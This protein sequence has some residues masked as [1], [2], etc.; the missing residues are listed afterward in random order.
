[1]K[2][3]GIETAVLRIPTQ[4]PVALEF[5]EHKM[6]VALV[7]TDEGLTGLGYSLAFGGGGAEAIR[8][9]LDTR[10]VPLLVGED[11]LFVERH[12]ER[13]F[14]AD[15]GIKRQGVAAYAL[16]ALDIALWDLVGQVAGLPLYKLWGAVTDRVPAYGSGGWGNYA[17][18]DVVAKAE[19]YV[20]RGCRYYKVKIHHPD[21]RV[22]RER[23]ATVRRAVGDDIGLMV[24][25]NQKLDVLGNLRQA[26][27]LE[28]LGL[29]WYEEPVLADDIAAC[30]EVARS[31]RIPV[32]TGENAY[33]RYEFRELIA[34][35]A[36]RYLMPDVCRANGYSETLR[37]ARLA[38]AH[39]VQVSPHVV[40][41]LSL[42]VVGALPNGFLVE[43]MDWAPPDLFAGLAPCEDGQF[44]IPDRAGHGVALA[45]GAIE[46][47][48]VA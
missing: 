12:W 47:Y 4:K 17:I 15:R 29:V 28:D 34:A 42:H 25:V 48:R 21:P 14:R 43:Y 1:M 31:I 32:A 10:L 46:R 22:N 13:M 39:Q 44:R 30:A 3:T 33:T 40:H 36:A 18:G 27:L 7:R 20:G 38:A 23:V 35:R 45:P 24:D 6:V 16:S 11:P 8:V 37:I 41:E 5:A 26:A 2:I 9:Y 19:R